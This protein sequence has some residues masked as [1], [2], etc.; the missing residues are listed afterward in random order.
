VHVR[1]HVFTGELSLLHQGRIVTLHA[2]D[3]AANAR[4]RRGERRAQKTTETPSVKTA[5]QLAYERDH[6]PVVGPDGGFHN[7]E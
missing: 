3:L 7:P 2:V 5:A 6:R 4:A 1:R